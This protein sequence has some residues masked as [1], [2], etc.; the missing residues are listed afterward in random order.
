MR[1]NAINS[2][3]FINDEHKVRITLSSR[4][5]ITIAEDMDIF[6]VSKSATFINQVFDH[7]KS[8]AKASISIYLQKRKLELNCLFSEIDLNSKSKN[9]VIDHILSVEENDLCSKIKEKLHSDTES[10]LYHINNQ[11]VNYLLEDCEED[12]YYSRPGLYIRSVIE[13][14]CSLPFIERERI[15]RKNVYETIEQAC[16]EKRVLKIKA[17][18]FGREET[19]YVYPHKIEPDA[20]HTQSY[21]VCY[22]RKKEEKEKDKIVASFSMARINPPTMLTQKFHLN[23]QEIANLETQSTNRTPAY[24]IG[25]TEQIKVRLTN[26]GKESYKKKLFSRPEKIESLSTDDIYVFDCTHLQICNYFLPFGP[27]A[28]IISPQ[29]L[30]DR[31]QNTLQKACMLYQ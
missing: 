22:S 3:W 21:L 6:G 28:E 23:K 9:T 20:F 26:K 18:Y 14:Y 12:Q 30:R 31:F 19:F 16:R 17:P 8:E 10:K 2:S 27:E 15:Y 13:E 5:L 1:T 25:K 24:L 11:N 4:A 29:S 7:F